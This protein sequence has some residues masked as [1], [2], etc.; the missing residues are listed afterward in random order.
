MRLEKNEG[1][2]L[3]YGNNV[4]SHVTMT[5]EHFLMPLNVLP[6]QSFG[7]HIKEDGGFGF[8]TMSLFN[9]LFGDTSLLDPMIIKV[10]QADGAEVTLTAMPHNED[11][12]IFMPDWTFEILNAHEHVKVT[13]VDIGELPVIKTIIVR[14]FIENDVVRDLL[15]EHFYDFKVLHNN[16]WFKVDG[17][18]VIVEH[19][20][21]EDGEEI[22]L[23]R[24]TDELEVT[25]NVCKDI[26]PVALPEPLPDPLPTEETAPVINSINL[27][28]TR[29]LVPP[30]P[31]TEEE[32][33]KARE[34]RLKYF[35]KNPSA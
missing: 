17:E 33:R 13:K 24:L 27:D 18:T 1:G 23:G 26:L 34:A 6:I 7:D 4:T 11:V 35:E 16:V 32:K 19:L 3:S 2:A 31:P 5:D 10:S 28:E 30:V 22:M 29:E 12:G 8:I 9:E 21:G 14:M 20:L 15:E 25:I